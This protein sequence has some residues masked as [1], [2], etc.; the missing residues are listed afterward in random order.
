MRKDRR[1]NKIYEGLEDEIDTQTADAH[2]GSPA[3]PYASLLEAIV[4]QYPPYQG[5]AGAGYRNGDAVPDA[6]KN[7]E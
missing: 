6:E 4:F 3:K 1:L 7:D 2:A 5:S